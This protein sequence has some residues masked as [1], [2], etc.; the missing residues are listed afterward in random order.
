MKDFFSVAFHEIGH[1][2]GLGHS[3]VRNAVMSANYIKLQRKLHNDDILG[4]EEMYG[5]KPKI[6]KVKKRTTV[7]PLTT[8]TMK[9]IIPPS[10]IPSRNQTQAPIKPSN[11]NK[12]YDVIAMIQD[13][14]LMVKGRLVWRLNNGILVAGYPQEI[15]NVWNNLPKRITH[16]DAVFE[17]KKQNK[18]WIFV[19]QRIFIYDGFEL[20]FVKM[21]IHLGLPAT[22][23][24][25]DSIFTLGDKRTY[26]L[27]GKYYWKYV[28]YVLMFYVF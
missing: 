13:E 1:S 8:T 7:A 3:S 9:V 27:S 25:I 2:L 19:G 11:C 20:K 14:V 23:K 18:V 22:L 24:K 12:S 28:E 15:D 21:L 26:I 17:N 6:N 4:L 5:V 16:I 10:R